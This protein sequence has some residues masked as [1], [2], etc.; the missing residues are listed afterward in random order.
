[1]GHFCAEINSLG[2]SVVVAV[3]PDAHGRLD[4]DLSQ[5]FRAANTDV[6]GTLSERQIRLPS[7]LG[8]LAYR[9]CSRTSSTKSV[10]IELLTRQPTMRRENTSTTKATYSQPCQVEA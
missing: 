2:Q 5:P 4:A 1:M 8:Y 9:A 3:A 7:R 6:L 10:R